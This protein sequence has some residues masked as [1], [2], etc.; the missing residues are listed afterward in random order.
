[1]SVSPLKF[2]IDRAG[3]IIQL[4][5]Q[6]LFYELTER[7]TL[8]GFCKKIRHHYLRRLVLDPEVACLD[9]VGDEE[10]T[11]LEMSGPFPAA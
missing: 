4:P 8:E 10:E 7:R 3:S 1:V 11:Y 2:P 9:A 6:D 5:V